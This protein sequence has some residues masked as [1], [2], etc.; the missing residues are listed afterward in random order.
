MPAAIYIDSDQL[1]SIDEDYR[2][3]AEIPVTALP[4]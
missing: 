3:F 2:V 1:Y 4:I